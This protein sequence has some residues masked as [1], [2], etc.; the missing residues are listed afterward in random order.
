MTWLWSEGEKAM[1]DQNDPGVSKQ[2]R[3]SVF[4]MR[5]LPIE[6]LL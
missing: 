3:L 4:L 2:R 5:L 1:S 6:G